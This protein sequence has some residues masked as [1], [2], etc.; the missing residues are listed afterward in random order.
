MI[1]ES[2]VDKHDWPLNDVPKSLDDD[3]VVNR[4]FE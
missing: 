3:E 2:D 4:G 1:C